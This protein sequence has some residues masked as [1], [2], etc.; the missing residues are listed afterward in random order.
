VDAWTY[1]QEDSRV[2]HSQLLESVKQLKTQDTSS[3]TSETESGIANLELFSSKTWKESSQPRQ[4]T[5]NQ[6]SNMSSE[7]WKAWVT[8]QRQEYS[9]RVKLVH[10]TN[11]NGFTSLAYPT[12]TAR[13][14]KGCGNA[15]PRK[16]GKSRMDTLEA[17]AKFFQP[18]QANPNTNGKSRGS[19]NPKW[20]EQLMGLPT[21][22]TD[23]DSSAME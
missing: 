19:L 23:F 20:V 11:A 1:S 15:V 14:W 13:D 5:E 16:D 21:G 4:Q 8:E 6:F 17:V 18:A 12:P 2:S 9:Q 22:W 3:H 7:S 10:L